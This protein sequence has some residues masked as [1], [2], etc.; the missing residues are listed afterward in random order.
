MVTLR[1]SKKGGIADLIY[2]MIVIMV[3]GVMVLFGF[4]FMDEFNSKIQGAGLF[5]EKGE[6]AV[7]EMNDLYPTV[8]D[9]TFLWLM[10]GLCIVALVLAMLVA[11]HPVFFILYFIFLAIVIYVGGILSNVYQEMAANPHMIN[12]ADQLVF[13]SHILQFLPIIIG[14]I[15]FIL[16]V[17]LYRTYQHSI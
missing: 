1:K 3:F 13:T 17:V 5:E 4:K 12:V 9:N 14:V 2:I 11:I 7:Q 6:A 15:G 10:I 8:I 16:A